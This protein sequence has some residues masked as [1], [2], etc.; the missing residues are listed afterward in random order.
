MTEAPTGPDSGHH[1]P[2]SETVNTNMPKTAAAKTSSRAASARVDEPIAVSRHTGC[3]AFVGTGPGDPGLLTVRA[4]EL[5]SAADGYECVDWGGISHAGGGS[6]GS[7]GRGD[8]L[9]PVV[10]E[11]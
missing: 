10:F 3:V 4:I 2:K 5:I 7:L 1:P 11:D 6:H 8:S 9:A